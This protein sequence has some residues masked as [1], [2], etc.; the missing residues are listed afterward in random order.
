M[1][2]FGMTRKESALRI[3]TVLRDASYAVEDIHRIDRAKRFPKLEVIG[4][5]SGGTI[6]L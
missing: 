2:V 5:E 6:P 3:F 4:G 1:L